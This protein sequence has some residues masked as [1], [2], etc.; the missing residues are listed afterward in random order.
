MSA[1]AAK[2]VSR[3]GRSPRPPILSERATES[4]EQFAVHRIAVGHVLGMPLH[5]ERK[6]RCIG[7]ANG[8]DRAVFRHA[9]DKDAPARL[10][11]ALAVQRIDAD[12]FGAEQFGKNAARREADLMAFGVDDLGIGIDFSVFEPERPMV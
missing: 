1:C 7:D 10:K 9:L 11:Y 12:G 3:C 5:A 6:A 2:A 8:L 4:L